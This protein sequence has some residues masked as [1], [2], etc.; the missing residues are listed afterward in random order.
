M[1]CFVAAFVSA[2]EAT[3][4]QATQAAKL[5]NRILLRQDRDACAKQVDRHRLDPFAD[6][7]SKRQ[8]EWK[9]AAK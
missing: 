7:M 2:S 8:A 6:W 1:R 5:S 4:A 9:A 3:L